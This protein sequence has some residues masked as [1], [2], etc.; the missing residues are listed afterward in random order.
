MKLGFIA[1][2]LLSSLGCQEGKVELAGGED[3]TY[4]SLKGKWVLINYWAEWCEPCRDEIPELNRLYSESTDKN[5]VVLGVNFDGLKQVELS[6][7]VERMGIQFPVLSEDPRARWAQPSF[8]G[9]PAT[10]II[11]PEDSVHA[12]LIGA[13]TFESLL[14]QID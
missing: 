8:E 3:L 5:L 9:L 10:L 13:Q 7:S 12:V 2:F 11:D 4:S 6:D 14:D 1:L